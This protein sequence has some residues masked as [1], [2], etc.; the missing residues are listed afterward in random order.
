MDHCEAGRDCEAD[1]INA[2]NLE[3]TKE[4]DWKCHPRQPRRR[5]R[6]EISA[7]LEA[8]HR[9]RDLSGL[10]GP[11][12]HKEGKC[13]VSL[14]PTNLDTENNRIMTQPCYYL[15]DPPVLLPNVVG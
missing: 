4:K 9:R 3:L 13:W 15:Y 8:L 12:R 14:T 5:D 6:L 2:V 7:A 1:L 10:S 11:P